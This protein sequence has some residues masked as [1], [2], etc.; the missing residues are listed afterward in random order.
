[1]PKRLILDKIF[2]WVGIAFTILS[3]LIT[4]YFV[5]KRNTHIVEFQQTISAGEKRIDRLWQTQQQLEYRSAI[6]YLLD[7]SGQQSLAKDFIED[8]NSYFSV[9]DEDANTLSDLEIISKYTKIHQ[10]KSI[11]DINETYIENKQLEDEMHALQA[12]KDMI[13]ALA[14]L[15]QVIGFVLVI[16][17]S[18]R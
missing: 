8:T 13:K 10:N 9:D 12:Q 5:E 1:M 6:S 17:E 7:A 4:H 3:V 2:L 14:L 16:Y 11:N 18:R 15:L